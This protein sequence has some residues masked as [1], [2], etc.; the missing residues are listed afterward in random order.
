ME[1]R[2]IRKVNTHRT[3]SLDAPRAVVLSLYGTK[4]TRGYFSP[5]RSNT[6]F[7]VGDLNWKLPVSF[8]LH[9]FFAMVQASSSTAM[10]RTATKITAQDGGYK[11]GGQLHSGPITS[12]KTP[13]FR[14]PLGSLLLPH[15]CL[16]AIDRRRCHLIFQAQS[17]P[18]LQWKLGNQAIDR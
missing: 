8:T 5:G 13:G 11:K 12:N 14:T 10:A 6:G 7:S 9:G 4:V 3:I 18:N 15:F 17:H 16:T 1:W 2:Q